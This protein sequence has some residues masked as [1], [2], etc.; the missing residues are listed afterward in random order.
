M[1][2]LLFEFFLGLA[3][4]ATI[5]GALY[6]P[7]NDRPRIPVFEG[8]CDPP[9]SPVEGSH[10]YFLSYNKMKGDWLSAQLVCSWLHPNGRLAEFET[11]EELVDAT[12]FLSSE[13][14][15]GV[16]P[17]AAP[18]PWIGAVELSDSNE[19]VWASSNSSIEATNWS[20]SRPNSPTFGD[21]VALDV[22]NGF[23]WIDLSNVTEVPILCEIPSNPPPVELTCPEGFFSLE[24]SCYAVFDDQTMNWDDAQTFCGSLAAGGRLVELETAQEIALFKGHLV[25]VGAEE[26]GSTDTYSWASSG[27]W[28]VFYD[29]YQGQPNN[30]TSGDAILLR[31]DWNWKWG[32][33]PKSES[34]KRPI[35]EAPPVEV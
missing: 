10:C 35:C 15:N 14:Q 17:W 2:S 26:F 5:D 18:G 28:V 24:D 19:F 22:A 8:Q 33:D 20:P 13:N 4:V 11:A 32:D 6:L 30:G 25:L 21:G 16:Y 12:V 34:T 1:H 31:C 3:L 29:W 23:E 7:S 9:F 27:Q